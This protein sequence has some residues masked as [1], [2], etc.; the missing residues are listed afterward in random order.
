MTQETLLQVKNLS[1]FFRLNHG[2]FH[3]VRGINFSVRK[4]ETMALVGESGSGKSVTAMSLVRLLPENITRYGEA[5]EIL[6]GGVSVLN[7]SDKQLQDLR[8]KRI[9]MIFQEPMTSLNPFMRIGEQ[10]M[11][12]V[13]T[14][15]ASATK[16][17]ARL[18][19]QQLLG[20][21]GISNVEKRMRAYPHE[22]SGGQL[23]RIMIAMALINEPDLLIA[24]EPTTA[25]D[26]T[27]QA[28]ILDLLHDLQQ[29]M[30]MA[31]IFITHDLGLAKHYSQTVCV[32]RLGEIVEEGQIETVFTH[33]QHDYTRM[34]LNA[35][36]KGMKQPV[37]AQAPVLLEANNIRVD[38]V[39][40]R[41]FFGKARKTFTA[42]ND[43]S[44]TVKDGQ[45]IGIV[46]ESGSGKST[47][48]KA[49]MQMLPYEGEV[50][51]E[52]K[53]LETMNARERQLQ[54]AQMQVVFQDPFGSLS[55]RLTIG[56][57][58]A[59]GL[60]VHRPQ[61]SKLQR[62]EKVAQMLEEVA[63]S[64]DMINRYPHEF[65][66]GQRQ[67]IAVARAL[68]LEPKFILLDEPTSAL[69]RSIQVKV[70]ELLRG[71]QQRYGLSYLFI[72]HDLSV[73]RAMSDEVLVMK[74]GQVVER[75]SAEQIFYQPQTQY[76]Q[77][78]IEAAF[79]L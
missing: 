68:I 4:G 69:D 3:A 8:G 28:E 78:L 58:I 47:L 10:L 16:A 21:V 22:F 61:L 40:E 23:Q 18:K 25:L 57:I 77:K 54:K 60:L 5:S 38:F 27:I 43:I 33:P 71:L 24:D 59:E 76:T 19:A 65:S 67:R 49:I 15:D 20:R 1:V 64:P 30:G 41:S 44:L 9:G 74:S 36:P 7:C 37:S 75:G 11:E 14:H 70:V 45:T 13:L 72:S 66:G 6:F 31:I 39:I 56:E 12:A 35:T 42:V 52:G 73:V 79:D 46:G 62:I 63:L 50:K 55:P 17:Q 2:E 51:F 26:V 29:Q 53:A 32:M 34:L 48:G